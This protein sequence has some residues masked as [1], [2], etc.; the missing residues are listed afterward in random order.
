MTAREAVD[1]SFDSS[2]LLAIAAIMQARKHL[3]G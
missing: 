2:N 3:Q 1:G